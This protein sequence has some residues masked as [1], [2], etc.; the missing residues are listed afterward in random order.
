MVASICRRNVTIKMSQQVC[1]WNENVWAS[2]IYKE[3][4]LSYI[5]ICM[6][7]VNNL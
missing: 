2:I 6:K 4:F 1:E 7:D 3:Y 5:Y